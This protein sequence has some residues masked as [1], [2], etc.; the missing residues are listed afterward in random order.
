M[1]DLRKKLEEEQVVQE[2]KEV[3][4]ES[5]EAWETFKRDYKVEIRFVDPNG[6]KIKLQNVFDEN[7]AYK[8]MTNVFADTTKIKRVEK[9]GCEYCVVENASIVVVETKMRGKNQIRRIVYTLENSVE[10]LSRFLVNYA[11]R[12]RIVEKLA[13][14][15]KTLSNSVFE[16]V[17]NV[18]KI[19]SEIPMYKPQR[20][21]IWCPN[22]SQRRIWIYPEKTAIVFETTDDTKK[23]FMK[24]KKLANPNFSKIIERIREIKVSVAEYPKYYI[25]L[26]YYEE[27][28]RIDFK[29]KRKMSYVYGNEEDAV[30]YKF[31][32]T[33][34]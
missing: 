27:A 22:F 8:I 14:V 25:E 28:G 10:K 12:E 18:R 5:I 31:M 33:F 23:A 7:G 4:T 16:A 24:L 9:D 30:V 21:N 32:Y 19:F 34:R 29:V 15:G 11:E 2:N 6:I 20:C 26:E 1:E 17:E 13:E 3:V